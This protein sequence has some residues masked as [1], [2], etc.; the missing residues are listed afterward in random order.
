[1]GAEDEGGGGIEGADRLFLA[2]RLIGSE[3][4]PLPV[5]RPYDRSVDSNR[6]SEPIGEDPQTGHSHLVE[7][8]HHLPS[9]TALDD[10]VLERVA[11]DQHGSRQR[12]E[13]THA[14]GV[15]D[16]C[17]HPAEIDIACRDLTDDSLFHVGGEVSIAVRYRDADVSARELVD[18][19]DEVFER[20][21][22]LQ[23]P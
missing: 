13:A 17:S 10:G 8:G 2:L 22:L 19:V 3:G 4:D 1:M 11:V 15:E 20:G 18:P 14:H 23:L 5:R 12:L 6:L 16:A 7:G 21:Q 9:H